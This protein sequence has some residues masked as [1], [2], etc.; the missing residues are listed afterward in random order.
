MWNIVNNPKSNK[1]NNQNIDSSTSNQVKNVKMSKTKKKIAE[2]NKT[3]K[4]NKQI[5]LKYVSHCKNVALY[6]LYGYIMIRHFDRL[7]F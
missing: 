7:T 6:T 3:N 1:K 5:N 4:I 2:S